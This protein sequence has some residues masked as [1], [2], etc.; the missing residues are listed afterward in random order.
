MK[1]RLIYCLSAVFLFGVIIPPGHTQEFTIEYAEGVLQVERHGRWLPA[2]LGDQISAGTTLRLEEG[3]YAE[4]TDG[5]TLLRLAEPGSYRIADL[6][7]GRSLASDRTLASM[8]QQR[9]S[10][11][12]GPRGRG[13][14]TAAGV[15]GDQELG[16]DSPE[17]TGPGGSVD[18]VAMGEEALGAGDFQQA[19]ALFADALLFAS[20]GKEEARAAFYLGYVHYL[21][22]DL[23]QAQAYLRQIGPVP[24]SE[25]YHEHV[26]ILAQTELELSMP[27]EVVGLLSDYASHPQH[28]AALMPMVHLLMGLGYRMEGN[29]REARRQL[30]EVVS[31]APESDAAG[32]A[33]EILAELP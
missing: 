5:H 2:Y 17:F 8:I 10:T 9:I 16:P 13:P 27:R 32:A 18:L 14:S 4:L 20:P 25:F 31:L 30:E 19:R 28:D 11:L 7:R 26:L 29:R 23:R 3:A 33:S 21:L 24:E 22:G 12:A 6:I 1:G 15:R